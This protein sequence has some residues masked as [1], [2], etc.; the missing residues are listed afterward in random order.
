MDDF[1][2]IK[3]DGLCSIKV[4]GLKQGGLRGDP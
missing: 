2:A 3:L 1:D 4:R